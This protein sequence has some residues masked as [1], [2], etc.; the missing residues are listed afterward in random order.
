MLL[1]VALL[2]P[3]AFLPATLMGWAALLG[4]ALGS[5]VLG[6]GLV[7]T[8]IGKTSPLLAGLALLVQPIIAG[9]LGWAIFKEVPGPL[10]LIGAAAIL[11][12]LILV[13]LAPTPSRP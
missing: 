9:A 8:G 12:A 10:D 6:Q 1:P 11:A 5:Q 4:L 3:G 7:I 13:R 2:A